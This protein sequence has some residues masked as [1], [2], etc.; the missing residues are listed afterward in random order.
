M[1]SAGST[2]GGKYALV[3]Q[4]GEGGMATVWRAVHTMLDREVAV[5]FIEMRG[6][7]ADKLAARFL[8]EARIAAAVR[9]RNVVDIIDFG[10]TPEGQPYMVMELLQG[11]S[12]ADRF[13]RTPQIPL[14]DAIAIVSLAL[15]G[16]GAVHDKG[17][18]HR[19]LKPENIFLVEDADGSFPKLLDF[20]IS[21]S[22]E[23][24]VKG[25]RAAAMTQEGTLLGT[26][27]YM[28]P[29]QA[30][31]LKDVDKRTDLYSM[32]VILYEAISGRLPL[33][34]E[35]LGDLLMMVIQD[36]YVPLLE[37]CPDVGAAVSAVVDRALAKNRDERFSEAR[38]MRNAL[39]EAVGLPGESSGLSQ[40]MAGG[41]GLIRAHLLT[42]AP[43]TNSAMR[44]L[45]RPSAEELAAARPV[46]TTPEP[47]GTA[48]TEP[49][50]RA[51]E[52]APVPLVP[53][54]APTPRPDPST[55]TRATR[56]PIPPTPN[57]WDEISQ[58]PLRGH[59]KAPWVVLAIV[60]LGVAGGIAELHPSWL[61]L[62]E[63]PLGLFG[64]GDA[65]A[66]RP[67]G[68][69]G[70]GGSDDAGVSDGGGVPTIEVR[71]VGVPASATVVLDDATYVG[72]AL[73]ATRV[74]GVVVVL[75]RRRRGPFD[76][77][78]TAPGFARWHARRWAM[79]D[80]EWTVDLDPVDAGPP[81]AGMPDAGMPDAGSGEPPAVSPRTRPPSKIR[82]P[83]PRPRRRHR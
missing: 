76:V 7:S 57:A 61:G 49:P 42:P 20:G 32:G 79:R 39:L 4:I 11:E 66:G 51:D 48:D 67:V 45:A 55:V 41:S 44:A 77:E 71:L 5:K 62:A 21:K 50:P 34:S 81:D 37:L 47:M 23:G 22:I 74:D 82:R 27:Q 83:R 9:H 43:V 12:L 75:V 3:Q 30:R 65:A 46:A 54:A 25:N 24:Q 35:N 33:D 78:V 16:L 60:L 14:P 29:E 53:A 31:G 38:E 73:G 69:D 19:D 8:D 40:L 18:V 6:P 17:I 1:H 2:I 13:A 64:E 10:T 63:P 36:P 52:T 28:S 70:D 72:D 80:W 15:S 26:P 58:P 59:S 56:G 68:A